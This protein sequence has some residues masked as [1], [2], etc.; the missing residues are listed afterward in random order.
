MLG[1]NEDW[2]IPKASIFIAASIRCLQDV[3]MD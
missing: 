2:L 3:D 1:F